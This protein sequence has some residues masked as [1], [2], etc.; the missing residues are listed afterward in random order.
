MENEATAAEELSELLEGFEAP[1][2]L[3]NGLSD[4]D[5]V[6]ELLLTND[7]AYSA[8]NASVNVATADR[9]PQSSPESHTQDSALVAKRRYR[10]KRKKELR[11]LRTLSDELSTRLEDL[12]IKRKS[13]TAQATILGAAFGWEHI[14]RRQM[15]R[16]Y[17][18]EALNGRL[19]AQI[20]HHRALVEH[21]QSEL[22]L[23]T[24][25]VDIERSLSLVAP[26]SKPR[27]HFTDVERRFIASFTTDVE[28]MYTQVD[29]VLAQFDLTLRPGST[30][31]FQQSG[32]KP[33][34]EYV[35]IVE[36]MVVP[37]G[38]DD[39]IRAFPKAM[40]WLVSRQCEPAMMEVADPLVTMVIKFRFEDAACGPAYHQTF[41]AKTVV[42]DDR[43]VMLWRAYTEQEG[44]EA[45]YM[46]SG[47][48][49]T[50][51]FPH[52]GD[53][54]TFM[55]FCT[56]IQP[57][58]SSCFPSTLRRVQDAYYGAYERC[59]EEEAQEFVQAIENAVIDN[60]NAAKIRL[61]NA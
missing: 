45:K 1:E 15:Q 20:N 16:R 56:R 14:A 61:C 3:L 10:E 43:A 17:D 35:D 9:R 2:L 28:H 44:T 6:D 4:V 54:A 13:T 36:A 47:W 37:F 60:L 46:E 31:G 27:V 29:S 23:R 59:G 48:G 49:I 39:S 55:Q 40:Q 52:S 41:V 18:A 38:L 22:R 33:D 50:R 8:P 11:D 57:L 5:N 12:V 19:R 30:Y 42:E 58:H 25:A 26:C 34:C 53:N 7:T 32:P 21:F 24:A 51:R